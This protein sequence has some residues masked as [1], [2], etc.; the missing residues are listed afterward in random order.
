MVRSLGFWL[1]PYRMF[2]TLDG[3]TADRVASLLMLMP[4]SSHSSK[5]RSRTAVTVS[6][7]AHPPIAW[8][9]IAY[10]ISVD[11][12]GYACYY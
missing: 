11:N 7:A 9:G 1:F 2:F 6:I 3:G 5:M 8:L 4:R 10:P 12:V